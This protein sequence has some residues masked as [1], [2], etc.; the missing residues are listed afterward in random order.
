MEWKKKNIPLIKFGK[1]HGMPEL[2]GKYLKRR[3][4]EVTDFETGELKKRAA[5][6]FQK[7][8]SPEQFQ[9]W[10]NAGL[11]GAIDMNDIQ[12]GQ[13]IKLVHLGKVPRGAGKAGE[14]NQYDVFT[15]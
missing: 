3:E 2:I 11:K 15:L 1:D 12:E 9:V 10:E 7:L 14:V 13:T 5:L 6:I 8:D 4:T